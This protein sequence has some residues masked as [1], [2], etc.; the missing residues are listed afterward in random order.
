MRYGLVLAE[1]VLLQAQVTLYTANGNNDRSNANL[2]EYELSPVTVT[3]AGFGKLGTFAVD[4]QVYAQPLYAAGVALPGGGSRNVLYV[5]TMHN[6]V[7]AFDADAISGAAAAPLWHRQLGTA[8]PS[9]LL[10]GSSQDIA[11]EVGILGTG[12]IDA[13]RGVLYV[14]SDT[15]RDGVPVFSLHALDLATGEERLNGPNQIAAAAGS[16]AFIPQQHIQRPGLLL[17]NGAVYIAFGSHGDQAPW[18]GWIMSY[19][20]GDLTRQLGVFLATPTGEGGA[21]WQS[22]R[23]L[24]ADA[25]GTIYAISGNGD[26]DGTWNFGQSF[27]TLSGAAP[28]LTGFYTPP[29]W[30][31]MSDNDFD[32]SAGPALVSGTH[33]VIGGDKGGALYAVDGDL[34]KQATGPAEDASNRFQAS[35]GSIF[36]LA[37]W[38]QPG[39][40]LIFAQG[41][42][43]L[44][45][46]FRLTGTAIDPQPVSSTAS[47]LTYSRIGMALSAAGSD[48]ATGILWETSG[49]YN[50]DTPGTLHAYQASNLAVELWNSDMNPARDAMGAV[51]KFGNPTVAN[52]RVYVPTFAN[53]IEVY[54]LFQPPAVE[55]PLVTSVGNAASF[56]QDAISPGESISLFGSRLGPEGGAGFIL[57]PAGNIATSLAGTRVLFDGVPA[58]VLFAGQAQ[59]NTVVPFGLVGEAAS[60][61]VE[62][63]GQ[64]SAPVEM[65]VAPTTPGVFS[66]DG[67]G[68]GPAMVVN[69]DGSINSAEH[70]APAGSVVTLYATG[71]GALSPAGQD[72]A[73]VGAN[74]APQTE[75][76]ITAL[77]NGA[78]ATVWYAGGAPGMVQGVIQVNLQ[79]PAATAPGS[80]SLTL[81]AGGRYSQSGITIMVGGEATPAPAIARR[82]GGSGG[83]N[84]AVGTKPSRKGRE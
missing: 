58:P 17:A 38:K 45:K 48:L 25:D 79:I 2:Q 65:A 60:V 24:A 12:A 47:A 75:A 5:A 9:S 27:L 13:A 31:S 83:A 69:Q 8:V 50:E 3:A 18:H 15:L 30:E 41:S 20:A 72:G 44:L 14:V 6:S 33:I 81:R 76:S 29:D 1:C 63:L 26:F 39:G 34:M 36:N 10:Y 56:E 67:S 66:A 16:V 80:A 59:V 53:R 78:P 7:Y 46:S 52:G 57:D 64:A 22:G 37:V 61:S 84:G 4:G 23:G 55:R 82:P 77:V 28:V 11:N 68:S 71:T 62:Y 19:D 70:P 42:R 40:A 49:D 73:V 43:D 74:D 21:F 35:T 54:G 51:A 32:L